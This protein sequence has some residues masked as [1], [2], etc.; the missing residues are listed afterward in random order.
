MAPKGD[1][2]HPYDDLGA[3]TIDKVQAGMRLFLFSIYDD[4]LYGMFVVASIGRL[5]AGHPMQGKH[6]LVGT[7]TS[8]DAASGNWGERHWENYG[9]FASN[10]GLEPLFQSEWSSGVYCL[11]EAALKASS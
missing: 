4:Q 2:E 7:F 8:Y 9:E 5:E 3:L 10:L 1:I 6:T 11:D